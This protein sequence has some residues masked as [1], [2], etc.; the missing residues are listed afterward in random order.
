MNKKLWI[1][2]QHGLNSKLMR[3]AQKFISSERFGNLMGDWEIHDK[4]QNNP[5][6]IVEYWQW[7]IVQVSEWLI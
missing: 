7:T 1:L 5:T 4:L 6:W 2:E 3:K